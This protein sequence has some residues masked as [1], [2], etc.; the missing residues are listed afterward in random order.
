[1]CYGSTSV[2]SNMTFYFLAFIQD[3]INTWVYLNG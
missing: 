2:I 1:M 3:F